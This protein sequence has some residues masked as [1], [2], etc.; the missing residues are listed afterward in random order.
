[1]PY[2]HKGHHPLTDTFDDDAVETAVCESCGQP[3][4]EDLLCHLGE[5]FDVC[6][7][8]AKQWNAVVFSCA[9]NWAEHEVVTDPY[10]E[11]GL[12]CHRCGAWFDEEIAVDWFP[13]ISDGY[14]PMPSDAV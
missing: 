12:V 7:P 4:P 2:A 13:L 11:R 6:P 1:V 10:G 8:C 3:C 9:H 5:D 14:V